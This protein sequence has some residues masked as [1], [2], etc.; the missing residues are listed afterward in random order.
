VTPELGQF[1]LV[2][3]VC[4]ALCQAAVPLAG[5]FTGR[6]D[7]MLLARP[8]AVGQF[9]FVGIAF[10]ALAYA[11]LTDDFSVL[12]VAQN[13][14]SE[15]PVVYKFTAVWGGHEGSLLLWSLMLATWTVAVAFASRS[16]PLEFSSRVI[17]VLGI[18]SGGVLLFTLLTSNPFDRLLPYPGDGVDLNPLLQDPG[19]VMHPPMLYLGYVGMA[20]PFAFAVAA[21][22]SGR[23]DKNWARW[24]RPWTMG[25]WVFLTAGIALGSWWAYYEVGWGG[26]WFWDPVE[27]ASFMPWLMATALLHSLAVTERRGIFKSW[28]VLLAIAAFTL[29]LLGTFLVRSGVIQSVHSFASDPT[30]GLFILGLL[31]LISGGAFVLYALRAAS[32]ESEGGF[33]LVSRESFLLANNILLVIATILILFGTLY[34]LFIDAFDLPEVSIGEP[35]FNIVFILPMLPLAMLVGLGM[36]SAWQQMSGAALLRQLRWPAAASVA[37]ALVLP[38]VFFQ[39]N[40]V[41][42]VVGLATG[43]WVA[44]CSLLEPLRR[45][46][47]TGAVRLT[48]AQ[49]GMYIAHL[50]VGLFVVAATVTSGYSVETDVAA[51]VGQSWRLADYDVEFREL[52]QVEGPNF[53]ADE[54][55]FEVRLDGEFVTTLRPQRRVYRVRTDPMTESS[56]DAGPIRDLLIALSDPVGDGAW[57][58][59]ARYKPFVRFVWIGCIVMALGGLLAAS[60]SRYRRTMPQPQP[61]R[62]TAKPTVG[63]AAEEGGR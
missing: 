16:Q 14:Q 31:V 24:T 21:L 28:T 8:A 6:Q 9:V 12:F 32:L 45:A 41:M 48:R 19:M 25:A 50:G 18:V 56:I 30:R 23:L 5:S 11:F 36:H 59:H 3:A 17:G 1:A 10:A 34:P 33:R 43:I 29:S 39:T 51:R 35:Y 13:S 49:W 54:G 61:Q 52:R 7:L 2:L 20:V 40:S 44:L 60:D 55:E 53:T 46:F 22:L 62:A 58:V 37:L 26:W 42:T 4:L 63:A 57:A 27:N 47:S 38:F 15:L